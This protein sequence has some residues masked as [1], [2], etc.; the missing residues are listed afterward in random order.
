MLDFLNY[1]QEQ[2]GGNKR[3]TS[4]RRLHQQQQG[5]QTKEGRPTMARTQN[6][7]GTA[8]NVGKTRRRRDLM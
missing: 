4:N 2:G 1:K 7:A 8:R 3:I 6:T 5:S